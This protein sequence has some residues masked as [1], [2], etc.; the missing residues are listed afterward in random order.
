VYLSTTPYLS[1]VEAILLRVH[2]RVAGPRCGY[3]G[4]PC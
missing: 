1:E 2:L 3:M 4:V